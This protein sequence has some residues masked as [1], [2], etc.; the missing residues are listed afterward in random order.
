MM[1]KKRETWLPALILAILVHLIIIVVIINMTYRKKDNDTNHSSIA[2]STITTRDSESLKSDGE[3]SAV[4]SNSSLSQGDM[5]NIA[6][7]NDATG[8]LKTQMTETIKVL[9][10]N[11][12][13]NQPNASINST[14][15]SGHTSSSA[16]GSQSSQIPPS[17]DN[18]DGKASSSVPASAYNT[19]ANSPSIEEASNPLTAPSTHP[20]LLE[21]DIPR[22]TKDGGAIDRD[23]NQAK[24]DTE[25]VN[26]K[27]SAAITEIKNRNQQ[28]ID[29]QR[30]QQPYVPSASSSPSSNTVKVLPANKNTVLTQ[31]DES[32]TPP[33]NSSANKLI[34]ESG[35]TS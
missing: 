11:A 23:Y 34:T 26:D 32:G 7:D 19:A 30:Q 28:K 20:I 22:A 17:K 5:G 14:M 18:A 12:S 10:S 33:S 2:A 21:A 24:D 29:Q 15:A 25:A 9:P 27:L 3:Q 6:G 13:S 1:T 4:D 8:A 35:P 16:A 31:K